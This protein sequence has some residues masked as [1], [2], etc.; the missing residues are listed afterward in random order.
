MS[1]CANCAKDAMYTYEVT[2]TFAI[3]YCEYHLPR[4]LHT[5]KNG[6]ILKTTEVFAT[7]TADA[8]AALAL[9]EEAVVEAPK[10]SK[11]KAA[12]VDTTPVEAT[13]TE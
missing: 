8:L 9:V 6:G 3:D 13:P 2:D 11:K 4:F 10:T 7:E 5:M 1:T 12:V